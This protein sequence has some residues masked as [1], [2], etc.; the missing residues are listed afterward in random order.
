MLK[1]S[2]VF[3]T[4]ASQGIGRVISER[5]GE[6]G[7]NIALAARSDGIDETAERIDAP[8]RTLTVKTDVTDEENIERSIEK[9]VD[10]FG[11]LDILVNNAGIAGPV[12]PVH[13]I[14]QN[15]WDRVQEVNVR[16]PY[17]CIKH[18][19]PYLRESNN[20]SIIN[21]AS[22]GGKRPYP[23]R[24]PYAASKMALIGMTRTLAYE[25]G[26]D[27]ITV[28]SVCPGP[29]KGERIQRAAKGQAELSDVENAEPA[30]IG[31]GDF[32]LP[33]FIVEPEE[34][35]E[36]VMYLAGENGRHVT[37]QDINIDAGGAWY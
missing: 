34:V 24:L 37:A 29:V 16:G 1:E 33:N 28:N 2:T 13:R 3:V 8:E 21:I 30:D 20:A 23:N 10:R 18:A 5:F 12:E 22:I 27:D 25:L 4:G 9:T 19:V 7:A 26:K 6:E 15:D 14:S 31:A 17:L 35:A 11:G 36:Q 32:A